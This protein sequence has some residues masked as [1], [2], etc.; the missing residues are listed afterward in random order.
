MARATGGREPHQPHVGDAVVRPVA[1]GP[2]EGH[3]RLVLVL[4]L[5]LVRVQPTFAHRV[6]VAAREAHVV[7]GSYDNNGPT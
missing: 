4:G 1:V 2:P 3:L 5:V 7:V 6:L